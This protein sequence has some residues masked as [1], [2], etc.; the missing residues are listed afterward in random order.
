MRTCLLVFGALASLAFASAAIAADE[1]EGLHLSEAEGK[2]LAID[3]TIPYCIEKFPKEGHQ[4]E[5]ARKQWAVANAKEEADYQAKLAANVEVAKLVAE[6]LRPVDMK[7]VD[8]LGAPACEN[9]TKELQRTG[10]LG[11]MDYYTAVGSY[12]QNVAGARVVADA[13][14]AR[15]A[16]LADEIADNRRKWK[17]ADGKVQEEAI[18]TFEAGLKE[19][20]SPLKGVVAEIERAYLSMFEDA[21]KRG[22]GESACRDFFD[23]LGNGSLRERTPKVFEAIERGPETK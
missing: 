19:P 2:L 14:I 23:S 3:Q 9:F 15:H 12:Y 13:C 8:E 17:Q 18:A 22:N 11:E 1:I 4:L 21:E 6:K 10:P 7:M 20:N 16:N 5:L